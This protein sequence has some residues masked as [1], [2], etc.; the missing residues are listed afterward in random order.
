MK[1]WVLIVSLYAACNMATWAQE[2]S[3]LGLG[4]GRIWVQH[5]AVSHDKLTDFING[6]SLDDDAFHKELITLSQK[7]EAMV[8]N[9]AMAACRSGEK[10]TI[11]SHLE[12]I[13]PTEYEPGDFYFGGEQ[14]G[15]EP[16][17]TPPV[18]TRHLFSAKLRT[19]F[20][21][22]TRNVGVTLEWEPTMHDG[23][24]QSRVVCELDQRHGYNSWLDYSDAW[25]K[26]RNEFPI[27][28]IWRSNTALPLR[29]GKFSL[30][31]VITPQRPLPAPFLQ[32]QVLVFA[33]AEVIPA[34]R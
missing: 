17:D 29:N 23:I 34:V 7:N 8:I 27:Y 9:T 25:G 18:L 19:F 26:V 5:I 28:E 11:E 14:F 33:R 3:G 13:Y 32:S 24:T 12:D 31:S 10:V 22:E 16:P 4:N 20:S 2:S 1:R 6:D 30:I 15:G 21:F